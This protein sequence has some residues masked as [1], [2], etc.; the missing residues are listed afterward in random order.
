[1]P[2]SIGP[3]DRKLLLIGGAI[4]LVLTAGFAFVGAVPQEAG[5]SIPSTYSSGSGGAR[6]AYLLLQD[7]HYKVSRWERSPTELPSDPENAVLILADPMETPSRE[8]REALQQF[9]DEGGQ[10]IFTGS[11]IKSFF[12]EAKVDAEIPTVGW[13]TFSAVFPS[14]YTVGASKIV[15]Q[16]GT[17]WQ[18]PVASQLPLY[19]ETRSPVVVSWRIGE[20]RILWWAAATP[21][22][23][24][25]ISRE[26]NLNLFLNAM[27][28]RV[29]GE[30]SAVQIY[31]DEYFHGQRTSLWS[32][33]RKTPVA[34]GLVQIAVLGLIVFFT[35][36][37][38]S[39]PVMLPPVVSRLSPL[40]FVDTLGGLYERAGAEPAVVGFVYQ[41]FR[42]TLSRQLRLSSSASDG[43]LADAVQGRL[44][45]KESGLKTTMARAL[46]ASRARKVAPE[47]ALGL[48]REVERY[49]E[50]LG[51]K[52]KIAKEKR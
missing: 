37:R 11:R 36:G 42:A 28:S 10:V 22:T 24:S 43:E 12:P 39:G 23:N 38:R 46:V 52:K 3:G 7:L 48:I 6:A 29:P 34:W 19:G 26:G 49:E 35:Y 20:G 1:M 5:S 27:N 21:L 47:E 41:R 33:V 25:G 31:W 30:Q 44:G 17:T 45:W 2:A 18:A 13:K 9:V 15:L 14:N 8:E 50:Q 16:T 51:L 40:E 32:Y 4:L